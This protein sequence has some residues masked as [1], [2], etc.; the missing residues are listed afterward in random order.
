MK[1]IICVLFAFIIV[2]Q[3][4]AYALDSNTTNYYQYENNVMSSQAI[5]DRFQKYYEGEYPEVNICYYPDYFGGF[6]FLKDGK[7]LMYISDD[8]DEVKNEVYKICASKDISFEK[9]NYSFRFLFDTF[10][11]LKQRYVD[12]NYKFISFDLSA[13]SINMYIDEFSSELTCTNSILVDEH[14]SGVVKVL[15]F[16]NVE[17]VLATSNYPNDDV[18]DV[19][20]TPQKLLNSTELGDTYTASPTV[21]LPAGP[22]NDG[23]ST[24]G[25]IGFCAL[26]ANTGAKLLITHGHNLVNNTNYY[27]GSSYVG[28]INVIWTSDPC[29]LSIIELNEGVGISNRLYSTTNYIRSNFSTHASLLSVA[30]NSGFYFRGQSTGESSSGTLGYFYDGSRYYMTVSGISSIEGDSGAPVYTKTSSTSFKLAGIQVGNGMVGIRCTSL[31][32]IKSRWPLYVYQN[33]TVYY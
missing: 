10:K 21:I 27:Y 16:I 17:N 5:I 11:V 22:G 15:P 24:Y 6:Q 4:T 1:R 25:T 30:N 32:E 3:T 26:D 19:Y 8:S 7:I 9:V 20:K 18:D 28:K 33:D 31:P 29:D 2:F 12:F 13:N 14:L 23:G